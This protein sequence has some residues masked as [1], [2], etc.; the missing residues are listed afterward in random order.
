MRCLVGA[1][2]N[3]T[4]FALSGGAGWWHMWAVPQT[5]GRE[6]VANKKDVIDKANMGGGMTLWTL[7]VQKPDC[8][9]FARIS[10]F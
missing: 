3:G 2:G 4:R 7:R 5:E 10:A 8:N 6:V 9:T 1:T